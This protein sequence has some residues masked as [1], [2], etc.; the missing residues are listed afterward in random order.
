MNEI[1]KSDVIY[2][3]NMIHINIIGQGTLYTDES[4]NYKNIISPFHRLYFIPEGYGYIYNDTEKI[5]LKPGFLYFIPA[6]TCYSYVCPK[7][8]KQL[9]F[10]FDLPI[11]PGLDFFKNIKSTIY[12]EYDINHVRILEEIINQ[13]DL[14]SIFKFKTMLDDILFTIV[15]RIDKKYLDKLNFKGYLRQNDVIQYIEKNLSNQLRIS[16]I[17]LDLNISK[18]QLCKD[19]KDDLNMSLKD[20]INSEIMKKSKQLLLSTSLYITEISDLLGF[21]DPYYFSRFFSKHEN[22]SPREFRK[23]YHLE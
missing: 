20:Y 2:Y 10:H 21:T 7:Y 9:Y 11:L 6:G 18:S 1:K 3:A 22:I 4:W 12:F 5:E 15:D 23:S 17:A 14:S 19:F 16:K 8:M 13:N